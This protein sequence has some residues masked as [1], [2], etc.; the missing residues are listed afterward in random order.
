M[1]GRLVSVVGR[2]DSVVGRLGSVVGRPDSVVSAIQ[3]GHWT[4]GSIFLG[5]LGDN[6]L[7]N[8]DKFRQSSPENTVK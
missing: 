1:V 5:D 3:L 2:L 8:P 4:Q 7:D 6:L